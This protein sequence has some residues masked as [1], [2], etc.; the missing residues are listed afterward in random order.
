MYGE[1]G[2]QSNQLFCYIKEA[3]IELKMTNIGDF[4]CPK[5]LTHLYLNPFQNSQKQP[6]KLI[7]GNILYIWFSFILTVLTPSTIFKNH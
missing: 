3:L 1:V 4:R 6:P 7:R 5:P 2:L